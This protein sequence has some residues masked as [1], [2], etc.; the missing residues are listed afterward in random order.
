MQLRSGTLIRA[1]A[2]SGDGIQPGVDQHLHALDILRARPRLARQRQDGK[3]DG[4]DCEQL[5]Q[6]HER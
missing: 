5:L 3:R 1:R 2:G 6:V 4:G